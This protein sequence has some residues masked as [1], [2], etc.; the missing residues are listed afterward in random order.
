MIMQCLFKQVQQ[1]Y[2]SLNFQNTEILKCSNTLTGHYN[3][4]KNL[5]FVSE[6]NLHFCL[7]VYLMRNSEGVYYNICLQMVHLWHD[8]LCDWI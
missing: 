8:L 2:L 4:K 1:F 6:L 7:L 3:F 5:N